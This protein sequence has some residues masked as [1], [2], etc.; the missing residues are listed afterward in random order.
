MENT[1]RKL[2]KSVRKLGKSIRKLINSVRT[3]GNSVR[4]LRNSVRKKATNFDL[5]LLITRE[6]RSILNKSKQVG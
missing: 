3:L 1:V 4:K 6:L 5:C 2:G